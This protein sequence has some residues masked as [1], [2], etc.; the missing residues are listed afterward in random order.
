MSC[1]SSMSNL[2]LGSTFGTFEYLLKDHH[3]KLKKSMNAKFREVSL[4]S[5]PRESFKFTNFKGYSSDEFLR[6]LRLTSKQFEKL[7]LSNGTL[8]HHDEAR[9]FFVHLVD[10][11][12]DYH[13]SFQQVQRLI[14]QQLSSQLRR[15]FD[16]LTNLYT[17]QK[18]I[19]TFTSL[20]NIGLDY[21]ETRLRF[22][23]FK[24]SHAN[25]IDDLHE[26]ETLTFEAFPNISKGRW[27]L[28]VMTKIMPHI[29]PELQT[30]IVELD[31]QFPD[32]TITPLELT[33]MI[34]KE[35]SSPITEKSQQLVSDT[36]KYLELS[37]FV[38]PPPL[39]WNPSYVAPEGTSL[40][41]PDTCYPVPPPPLTQSQQVV[42]AVDHLD[43]T[44]PSF[45]CSLI[46]KATEVQPSNSPRS[47]QDH[48]NSYVL[49]KPH[50]KLASV[51]AKFYSSHPTFDPLRQDN[52]SRKLDCIYRSRPDMSL[53][54]SFI[55]NTSPEP[56]NIRLDFPLFKIFYLPD[57]NIGKIK[58]TTEALSHFSMFCFRCGSSECSFLN[59]SCPYAGLPETWHVCQFCSFGFHEKD[60]C[61][62]IS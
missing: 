62:A 47:V 33:G 50:G 13:L 49:V 58:M 21:H 17:F 6:L 56:P 35:Q 42:P 59:P 29:S 1:A 45:S 43:Q 52:I 39:T 40:N 60:Q 25:I 36:T 31:L 2:S 12:K 41:P 37:N 19:D 16:S 46:P 14:K 4:G 24:P 7:E 8:T 53:K 48:S 11:N 57:K 10:L 38:H 51:C 28:L 55:Q 22:I 30:K 3:H 23:N 26:L 5:T 9:D 20:L 18:A 44:L 61:K 15:N 34:R 27:E 54:R 32:S